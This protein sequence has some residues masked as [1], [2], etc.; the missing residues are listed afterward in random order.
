VQATLAHRAFCINLAHTFPGYG[1]DVWGITASDSAKGYLAWGGPPLD[2]SIDGTVVPSAAGGSLMFT[3][4]LAVRA[5]R[6]MREKYGEKIYGRYGF[7]DAFNPNNGWVDRDVIGINQGIILIS[8]ENARTGNVWRWFMKN[9]EIPLAMRRVGLVKS[10]SPQAGARA[11]K[12]AP[13]SF[14]LTQ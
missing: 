13:R 3:P 11:E 10:V 14:A 12:T 6:T 5:L 2:P 8:A 7:I 9:K 1:P 4:E